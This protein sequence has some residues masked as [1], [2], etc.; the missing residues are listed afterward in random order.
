MAVL[1][2]MV[3]YPP[4]IYPKNGKLNQGL[5]STAQKMVMIFG[6]LAFCIREYF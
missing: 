2:K 4:P 3:D 6:V 1:D 5:K